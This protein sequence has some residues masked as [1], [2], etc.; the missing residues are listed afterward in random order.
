V[1][2]QVRCPFDAMDPSDAVRFR[3]LSCQLVLNFDEGTDLVLP[4]DFDL[5]LLAGW[6]PGA[7]WYLSALMPQNT[8]GTAGA[9][10]TIEAGGQV[11]SD[12][13]VFPTATASSPQVNRREMWLPCPVGWDGR[14]RVVATAKVLWFP[15]TTSQVGSWTA[16]A[17]AKFLEMEFTGYV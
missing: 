7:Q 5:A 15:G 14:G 10:L 17:G 16:N 11:L 12:S 3:T 2:G 8:S 1:G 6:S 13:L 9:Y 4:N